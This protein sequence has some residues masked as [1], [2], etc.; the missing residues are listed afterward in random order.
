MKARLLVR[1]KRRRMHFR[2]PYRH[3]NLKTNLACLTDNDGG[4]VVSC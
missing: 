2:D 4:V 1:Q 3:A